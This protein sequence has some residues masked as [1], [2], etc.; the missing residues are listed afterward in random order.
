MSGFFS[1]A[2]AKMS[3]TSSDATARDT[4]CRIAWS[5]SSGLRRSP[6]ALLAST[7]LTAWKKPRRPESA[8]ACSCGTASANA[9]DRSVTALTSRALPSV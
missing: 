5:I 4:I 1:P 8:R 9:F 7:A 6:G 3:M 2:A